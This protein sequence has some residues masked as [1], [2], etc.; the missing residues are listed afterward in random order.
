[1]MYATVQ[2]DGLGGFMTSI[3]GG[4]DEIQELLTALNVL[5]ACVSFSTPDEEGSK[6]TPCFC[7]GPQECEE[8]KRMLEGYLRIFEELDFGGPLGRQ[9][10][11]QKM[12]LEIALVK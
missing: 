7:E 4:K 2:P 8:F 12:G 10:A 9:L 11:L 5:G 3:S 6:D 1:M